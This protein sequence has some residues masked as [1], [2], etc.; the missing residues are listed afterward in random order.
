MIERLEQIF[1]D[2]A[3]A[4]GFCSLRF[5]SD[6]GEELWVRQNVL[7]PLRIYNDVG[8]MITVIRG[9]GM[10]YAASSDLTRSGV[11]KAIDRAIEWAEKTAE[12]SVVD[13]SE[14]RTEPPVGEYRTAVKTPWDDLSRKEKI[15]LLRRECEKMKIHDR[16]VDWETA[17]WNMEKEFLYL[18]NNGGR[19]RQSFRLLIPHMNVTAN[20]GSEFQRRSFGRSMGMQG[21]LET[22]DDL[23]FWKSATPL[24]EEA[25]ALLSAPNCPSEKMDLLL[26]ADQM[27]LQIHESIG[28]PLELDRILGDERNYAGTSFVTPEMFGSYQYGSELLNIS[29][30]PSLQGELSSYAFDDDG[31]PAK[32][33]FLIEKGILKRALGGK[34]S[35]TRSGI[36]GVANS[37]ASGWNRQPIDRMVNVN[38]EPGDAT[39]EELISSIDHGIYMKTNCSWSIDDSRNKFQFGCEWGRLIENGELTTVV[40][41]CNYRGISATFWRSLKRVGNRSTFKILGTPYCG[42]GEPNQAIWVGHATPACLFSNVDVFGGE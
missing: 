11:T 34:T 22:L 5:V 18:T 24:A 1:K 4:K 7:Q 28:H 8:V 12:T 2:V 33:E 14:I 16:I 36:P 38:L 30:D 26:D 39:M 32:K 3:P 23:G 6:R 29:V 27:I 17:L 21:G 41:K 13:Y 15:D 42:K 35:Q 19:V 10:G 9:N 20:E 31:T 37:R 25:L 40:K